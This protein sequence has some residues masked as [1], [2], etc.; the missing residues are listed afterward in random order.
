MLS[1]HECRR[2]LPRSPIMLTALILAPLCP[3]AAQDPGQTAHWMDQGAQAMQRG[4]AA[5]AE[6]DFQ[7]AIA[8]APHSAD[9]YLGLGMAQLREGKLDAAAQSLAKASELKPEIPSAHMF[10]GI[11]LFEMNS[12]DAAIDQLKE[13]I[14][15]QPKNSEA[16][17]WLGIIELQAG[18]PEEASAP[19]DEASALAPGDQ[20]ILAYQVRAHT[21]AAQQAF[22]TLYKINPDSWYVHRAQAEIDSEAHQPDKA[23]EEYKAAIKAKP[24]DP[25][26]YEALADEEQKI[27]NS[28]D[29]T[30]AYQTE[31]TL[32]PNDPIALFNLGK[33]QVETGDPTQGVAYLRQAAE[34]HAS[35]APTDFYLG[36]GLSKLGENEEAA[37]WLERVIGNS[38]SEF[39]LQSDYYELVRVY[40]KLNRKADSQRALDEL[41]KL[42]A[43]SSPGSQP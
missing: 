31:L 15:L 11:A 12:F 17:T 3:V 22:R 4:N 14:K 32:H 40:Q 16:L 30:N 21:L 38:P 39:I 25:D 41:K 2:F 6:Q 27:G 43:Q 1:R 18:K 24:G 33:I 5:D 28:V 10:R 23:I 8:S 26:L 35:P 19:L 9:A 29:A 36:L 34:A 7:R 42:K 13:E 37:T 20:N